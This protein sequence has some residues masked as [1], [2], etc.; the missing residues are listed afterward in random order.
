MLEYYWSWWFSLISL[1]VVWIWISLVQGMVFSLHTWFCLGVSKIFGKYLCLY[2]H[3]AFSSI[4]CRF[5]PA[6]A[7]LSGSLYSNISE[8]EARTLGSNRKTS[9]CSPMTL[10]LY[11][12]LSV[13]IHSNH[14]LR[15]LQIVRY[16]VRFLSSQILSSSD[17]QVFEVWLVWVRFSG[18][19]SYCFLVTPED[20]YPWCWIRQC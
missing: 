10:S 9:L 7:H 18:H 4:W 17:S 2:L 20:G 11:Y 16:I 12:L 1:V 15:S 3:L 8:V 6:N 5:G 19:P 14:Q 13:V